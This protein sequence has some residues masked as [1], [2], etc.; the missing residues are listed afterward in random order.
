MSKELEN[1]VALITGGTSGIGRD[2]TV[3]FAKVGA[4]V[5]FSGRREIEGKETLN[6]VRTAGGD[7]HFIKSDVSKSADAESLVQ[8]TVEKYG[9]LDVAFN[10]AG[11]EGA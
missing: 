4:K 10:N 3:L 5:I 7:G 9:R 2:T 11:I 6:L 8:K 1:K